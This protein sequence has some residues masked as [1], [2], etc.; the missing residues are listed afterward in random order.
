M[1]DWLNGTAAGEQKKQD[2]SKNKKNNIE[3]A[4][5]KGKTTTT[6]ASKTS[7]SKESVT[8]KTALSKKVSGPSL[9]KL[10]EGGS[11]SATKVSGSASKEE[12]ASGN[13]KVKVKKATVAK[14]VGTIPVRLNV[15][16][17]VKVNENIKYTGIGIYHSGT[18]VHN[19][20]WAYGGHPLDTSGI[21]QMKKPRDLKSLSD[22][23]G[24]FVFMQTLRIGFTSLTLE[25]V[26]ALVS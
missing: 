3:K 24:S 26:N 16:S 4:G 17:L 19:C 6:S 14:A 1:R 10:N 15:Y 7:T 21:F 18:E 11:K 25:Q 13:V 8:H 12:A 5:K 22:I 2:G 20:E 23:D 9:L